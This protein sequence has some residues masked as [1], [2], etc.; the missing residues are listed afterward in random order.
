MNKSSRKFNE[1]NIK[2]HYKEQIMYNL[3]THSMGTIKPC[4]KLK[5]KNF[6]IIIRSKSSTTIILNIKFNFLKTN[7]KN[8]FLTFT[9]K[10][11]LL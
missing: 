7:Q 4:N 1:L 5:I 10:N 9:N 11:Y 2:L 3:K 8:F 6:Q